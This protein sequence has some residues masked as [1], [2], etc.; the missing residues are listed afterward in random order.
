ML[1]DRIKTDK[2]D[3]R[4]GSPSSITSPSPRVRRTTRASAKSKSLM[5]FLILCL[6]VLYRKK[7]HSFFKTTSRGN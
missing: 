3:E 6:S 7:D 2:E 4:E 5:T 1:L